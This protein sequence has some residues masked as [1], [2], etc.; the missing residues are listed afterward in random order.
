MPTKEEEEQA[1][2]ARLTVIIV[3][4]VLVFAVGSTYYGIASNDNLEFSPEWMETTF[5]GK[6]FN[7]N[8][9]PVSMIPG[10]IVALFVFFSGYFVYV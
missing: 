9:I 3:I 5:G 1:R 7:K 2:Q 4:S 8:L 10:F 6:N